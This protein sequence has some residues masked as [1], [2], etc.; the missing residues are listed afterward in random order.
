MIPHK[1]GISSASEKRCRQPWEQLA[2]TDKPGQT[3][4]LSL[5]HR[6]VLSAGLH[7][8]SDGFSTVSLCMW[9][10]EHGVGCACLGIPLAPIRVYWDRSTEHSSPPL[11]FFTAMRTLEQ[12][13]HCSCTCSIKDCPVETMIHIDHSL[14]SCDVVPR[15]RVGLVQPAR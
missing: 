14:F 2:L 1:V 5:G 15:K 9:R 10:L 12:A 8:G 7:A 6:V 13:G 3:H 4:R 11:A